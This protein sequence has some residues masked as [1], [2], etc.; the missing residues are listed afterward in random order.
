[1]SSRV[2]WPDLNQVRHH[3]L[4]PAA[5]QGQEITKV[6]CGPRIARER[7]VENVGVADALD[8]ADRLF[9]FHSRYTVVCTVV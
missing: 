8:D 6:P 3:W 5:K 9:P 4:G 7:R 1:M 2:N